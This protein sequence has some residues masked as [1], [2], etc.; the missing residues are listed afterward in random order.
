MKIYFEDGPLTK[1]MTKMPPNMIHGIDASN[2]VTNNIRVL[3]D[4]KEEEPSDTV[5]YTNDI[6]A[7]NNRYAW[8]NELKVP[9]IY[10]RTGKNDTFIRIDELTGRV[11]RECHNIAHL[12][13]AGEFDAA[14]DADNNIK[15]D[16]H[17]YLI[18]KVTFDLS[19]TILEKAISEKVVGVIN[20]SEK[21][22]LQW[23]EDHTIPSD[24]QYDGWDGNTYPY[25]TKTRIENLIP[26]EV[27]I[28][29]E[30]EHTNAAVNPFKEEMERADKYD[31]VKEILTKIAM[32]DNISSE[33]Q[34]SPFIDEDGETKWRI[35]GNKVRFEAYKL[36]YYLEGLHVSDVTGKDFSNLFQ[37]V[38]TN[39]TML[40][41]NYAVSISHRHEPEI[42]MDLIRTW[43]IIDNMLCC[44]DN[45]FD[46]PDNGYWRIPDGWRNRDL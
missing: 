28:E 45:P 40:L 37:Y 39:T 35:D 44:F 36:L 34:V 46:E 5:V 9:E 21:T 16:K 23:I 32:D 24:K 18:K 38:S 6:S 14:V 41:H 42:D 19:E 22:A 12:Y 3:E 29:E 17:M 15:E 33:H 20:G 8:N 1:D 30:H 2:G 10:L 25:Y 43:L 27:S 13:L 11:L 4:I 31:D 26:D 7:L